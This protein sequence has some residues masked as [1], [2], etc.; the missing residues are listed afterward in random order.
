MENPDDQPDDAETPE[1]PA[2]VAAFMQAQVGHHQAQVTLTLGVIAAGVALV[3]IGW[4]VMGGVV[5]AAAAVITF[6]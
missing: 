5:L 3:A 4:P 2:D 6:T 1:G